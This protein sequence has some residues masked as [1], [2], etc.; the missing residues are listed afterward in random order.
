[1]RFI[2]VCL[3]LAVV[4]TVMTGCGGGSGSTASTS[5][6]ASSTGPTSSSSASSSTTSSSTTSSST[7]S[8]STTGSS[9]TG[10]S[11]SG[12]GSSTGSSSANNG[13]ATLSWTAPTTNSDGSALTDLAGYRIHYGTSADSLNNEITVSSAS[14]VSYQVTSLA[15]G[16]WYFAVTSY[17]TS[18]LE[19]S[20]SS[21]VSKTIS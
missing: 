15:V 11:S 10:T 7:T 6:S 9:S 18:G 8:S 16:T 2:K 21:V 20:Q 12:S 3:G 14:E 13:T 17:T 19:S 4:V 1:M 5:S